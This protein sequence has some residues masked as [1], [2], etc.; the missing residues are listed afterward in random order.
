M[1][2]EKN[3]ES[4]FD[5]SWTHMHGLL[6]E[7]FPEKEK[8]KRR[9]FI[10]WWYGIP[11][12]LLLIGVFFWF[13]SHSSESRLKM[14]QNKASIKNMPEFVT[15]PAKKQEEISI[16]SIKTMPKELEAKLEVKNKDAASTKSES[17]LNT[18]KIRN[19]AL[20]PSQLE[21]ILGKSQTI[22]Y[23]KDVHNVLK[24]N[25]EPVESATVVHKSMESPKQKENTYADAITALLPILIPK[26]HFT[27]GKTLNAVTLK[28][29]KHFYYELYLGASQSNVGYHSGFV[30]I[31]IGR[32]LN[33]RWSVEL[34]LG[35]R[36]IISG[37]TFIDSTEKVL[38]FSGKTSKY[39]LEPLGA[40]LGQLIV[41]SK[42]SLRLHLVELPLKLS[43]RLAPKWIIYGEAIGV[44][45]FAKE[46]PDALVF[47]SNKQNMMD[48]LPVAQLSGHSYVGLGGGISFGQKH[49][50]LNAGYNN[51]ALFKP[52]NQYYM[53]LK[54]RF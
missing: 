34:G 48:Y 37:K 41:G 51:W 21:Q 15:N 29:K 1:Q 35:Y 11:S 12:V 27:K 8:K 52:D 16:E 47:E 2:D 46:I 5:D 28:K 17:I 49:W 3:I 7:H 13:S 10:W 6:D 24:H 42:E 26:L 18:E 39:T 31:D 33:H 45:Q 44:Y 4:F 23:S 9:L 38:D 30:G 36:T 20:R 54:Y 53:G 25:P 50:R 22:G 32:S 14:K 43:Y 19:F 40:G